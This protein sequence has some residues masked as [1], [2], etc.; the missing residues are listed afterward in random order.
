MIFHTF[1]CCPPQYVVLSDVILDMLGSDAAR[2]AI[3]SHYKQSD[4][5]RAIRDAIEK[6]CNTSTA[7]SDGHLRQRFTHLI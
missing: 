5:P 4:E 1:F 3:L 7:N 6:A 2:T